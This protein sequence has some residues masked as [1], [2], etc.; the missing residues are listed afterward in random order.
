MQTPMAQ[1]AHRPRAH[2]AQRRVVTCTRPYRGA[3]WR[4]IVAKP[5]RVIGVSQRALAMSQVVSRAHTAVLSPPPATIQKLYCDPN[6][7]V[8]TT[9]CVA[10]T[11]RCVA[12][13]PGCIIGP[14]PARCCPVAALYRSHIA[15]YYNTN[16]HPQPRYKFCIATH[17]WPS[18]AGACAACHCA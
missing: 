6:P 12:R 4:H 3:H 7:V 16:G 13:T 2:C 15:P 9:R 11:T 5:G 18:H 14:V 10:R 17:P 1:A 8:R